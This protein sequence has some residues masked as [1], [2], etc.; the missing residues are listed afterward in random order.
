MQQ[1]NYRLSVKILWFLRV[2]AANQTAL[3]IGLVGQHLWT[4]ERYTFRIN[5]KMCK[6]KNNKINKREEHCQ[7]C[8]DKI[9]GRHLVV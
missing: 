2:I 1:N 3:R 4:L 8:H 9:A 5:V 6:K 7:L